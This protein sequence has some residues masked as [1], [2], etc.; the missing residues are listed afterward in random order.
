MRPHSICGATVPAPLGGSAILAATAGLAPILLMLL[1]AYP[2][3]IWPAIEAP[4]ISELAELMPA[5]TSDDGG[6]LNRVFFPVM[7]LLGLAAAAG[8]GAHRGATVLHPA[9]VVIALC[10]VWA[11]VTTLWSVEPAITTR[12]AALAGFIL[13]AVGGAVLSLRRIEDAM[14]VVIAF[15]AVLAMINTYYVLTRPPTYLGHAGIYPH[16]NYFGAV[17]A[18]MLMCSACGLATGPAWQRVASALLIGV[19]TW[20]L[21][22]SRSKTSLALAFAIPL[23]ALAV[24]L[25][26]RWL[27]I[28]PAVSVPA[29]AL[30]VWII[31]AIG[32]SGGSWDFHAVANAIFGDPTLTKRTD[33]WAFAVS[34]LPDRLLV[35][36]G[37]EVFWGAG[38]NSPSLRDA[39][40]WIQKMPHAHNGYIDVILQTGLVGLALLTAML[41]TGLHLAGRV[42]TYA[43]GRAL[44]YLSIILFCLAYNLLE[45]MWFRALSLKMILLI[46]VFVLM[47]REET[48]RHAPAQRLRHCK[49]PGR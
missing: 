5:Q 49:E 45:T 15:F 31:Y 38:P 19:L 4:P 25:A 32:A 11:A 36:H 41:L 7:A 48:E 3:L 17:A 40:G 43:P 9:V 16:K 33:I 46:A 29:G 20:H 27:R 24:L 10:I 14:P 8:R 39:P 37:F 23:L 42:A 28:S 2:A 35:G 47:A 34:K 6:V 26:A 1:V 12:R 30:A 22:E 21:V 18:A 44:F 13:V